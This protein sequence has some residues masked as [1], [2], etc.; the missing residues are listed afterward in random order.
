MNSHVLGDTLAVFFNQDGDKIRGKIAAA[1][2]KS[3]AV[4]SK[5]KSQQGQA[6]FWPRGATETRSCRQL[7]EA[8]L[9]IRLW[10]RRSSRL[11]RVSGRWL[12]IQVDV[13]GHL[14]HIG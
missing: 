2:V 4:T 13:P 7:F 3:K 12:S 9:A 6:T 8:L 5:C 14:A 11:R 1:Y 10:H